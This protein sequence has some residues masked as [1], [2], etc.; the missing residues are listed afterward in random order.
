MSLRDELAQVLYDTYESRSGWSKHRWT[1]LLH[2]IET[3]Q[4]GDEMHALSIEV[5]DDYLAQADAVIAHLALTEE[6]APHW[7]WSQDGVVTHRYV[8]PWVNA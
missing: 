4:P 7:P 6:T 1:D 3:R 8:T 2:D 5:R